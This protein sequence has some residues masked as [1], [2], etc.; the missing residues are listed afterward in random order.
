MSPSV[1]GLF[2]GLLLGLAVV[3][4]GFEA[5]AICLLLGA[6]GFVIGR[7]VEGQVDLGALLGSSARRR[8]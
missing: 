2:A 6:V 5:F 8:P 4:G 7:V 1:I 3:L